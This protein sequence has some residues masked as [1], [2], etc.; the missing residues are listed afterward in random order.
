MIMSEEKMVAEDQEQE[1]VYIDTE[2][3]SESE[4]ASV[5]TTPETKVETSNGDEELDSY[6]KGV[7]SRIKKLTE[8]YRKEERDKSEAVRLSQELINE[9]K[10]L[11]TRMQALDTGYLS[12]FGTRLQAQTEEIKRI[13]KE[14]YENGD[15]DKMVEAQQALAQVTNEQARYNT[16]KSRQEQQ[17]KTQVEA[18]EQPQQQQGPPQTQ[19]QRPKPDPQ[20]EQWAG[21]NKWFGEDRVMTAAAFAIHAQL[22]NEEGFDSDSSEYYTEVDKRIRS[23]FPHKFQPAKRSGGGSQVASAGNSASRSTKPG[24][25]TVKLTHSQ[26]AIAKKLGVPLEEYAKFVK[27]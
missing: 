7:Q 1:Q 12:E 2:P 3:E 25:R 23:E 4:S 17:A 27:D 24:R 16:A 18:A 10:Q 5:E 20:A 6:S 9:N 15:T 19:V 11:K 26:V 8:K 13:Y 22:T 14:A 21:R